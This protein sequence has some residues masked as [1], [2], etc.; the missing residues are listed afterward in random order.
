MAD[1]GRYE[2]A[3]I[4]QRAYE[5]QQNQLQDTFDK[6]QRTQMMELEQQRA[7]E[8]FDIQKKQYESEFKAKESAKF[9]NQYL[10]NTLQAVKDFDFYDEQG[11]LRYEDHLNQITNYDVNEQWDKYQKASRAAG[12]TPIGYADFSKQA[13]AR[14]KDLLQGMALDLAADGK[15]VGKDLLQVE[16][17]LAD[18]DNFTRLNILLGNQFQ[19]MGNVV[20]EAYDFESK[21][22]LSKKNYSPK[23]IETLEKSGRNYNIDSNGIITVDGKML[24]EDSGGPYIDLWW[25]GKQYIKKSELVNNQ[26]YDTQI[27]K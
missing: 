26:T 9:G 8:L 14:Y 7:Q 1:Y 15:S 10:D 16:Q 17:D 22:I 3:N 2:G 18:N 13:N 24:Q 27:R 12:H 23:S 19:E 21:K 6:V 11:N 25:G 20:N 5:N 4:I